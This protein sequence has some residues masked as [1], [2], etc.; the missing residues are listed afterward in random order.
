MFDECVHDDAVVTASKCRLL[1]LHREDFHRLAATRPRIASHI[2][3]LAVDFK[4]RA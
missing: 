2:R 1:K 3:S 4:D